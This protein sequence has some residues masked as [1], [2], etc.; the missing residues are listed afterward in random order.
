MFM[1]AGLLNVITSVMTV[2]KSLLTW[3]PSKRIKEQPTRKRREPKD[4]LLMNQV[5]FIIDVKILFRLFL[6][7]VYEKNLIKDE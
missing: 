2:E 3:H 7:Y 4:Q 6:E 5:G 1:N